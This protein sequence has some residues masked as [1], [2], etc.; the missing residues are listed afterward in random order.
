MGEVALV[1]GASRGIGR[2]I[3]LR[4]ARDGYDMAVCSR[5]AGAAL[6]AVTAEI[7]AL[8]RQ[9]FYRQCDVGDMAEVQSFV[10][11]AEDTLGPLT[12]VVNSAGIIKDHPLIMMDAEAWHTVL[13]T[14]LDGVFNVCRCAVFG[15]MK[16]KQG[17]IINISSVSGVYGNP[18]QANYSASKAGI[19]GFSK[20]VAKE[21]GRYGIRVNVVAPGFIST[22]MTAGLEGKGLNRILETIPLRRMGEV[23]DVANLVSFLASPQASYIT[24]QVIQVDGGIIL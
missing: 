23:E 2:A 19:I 12:L 9:V 11:A 1:T 10:E 3:A 17:C 13:T 20:A 8:G 24:G 21:V 5:Q 6:D 18:T 4:L 15:F 7:T 22:D 16:R 14:N